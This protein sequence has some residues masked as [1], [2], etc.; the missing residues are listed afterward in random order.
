M[1]E[2]GK[3]VSHHCVALQ[4]VLFV[5]RSPIAWVFLQGRYSRYRGSSTFQIW[6]CISQPRETTVI[7]KRLD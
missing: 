1:L 4:Q 7:V 2:A 5:C 6:Q 3:A